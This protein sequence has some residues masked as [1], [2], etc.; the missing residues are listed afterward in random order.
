VTSQSQIRTVL[1]AYK[2]SLPE[3]FPGRREVPKTLIFAKDDNHAE[4]I[5]RLTREVFGKGDDFCPARESHQRLPHLLQPAR[6]GH[7]GH[8]RHRHRH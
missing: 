5:V 8:D 4:E 7:G 2:D 1:T 3:L 6:R